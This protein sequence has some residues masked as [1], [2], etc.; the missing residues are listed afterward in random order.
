MVCVH[1]CIRL[2]RIVCTA[3]AQQE[4][5]RQAR[6]RDLFGGDVAGPANA[7]NAAN[8]AQWPAGPPPYTRTHSEAQFGTVTDI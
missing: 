6:Y 2:L 5:A 1:R 8:A 7:A 3:A 4:N